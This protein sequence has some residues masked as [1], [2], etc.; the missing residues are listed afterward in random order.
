M[1]G[2][3]SPS[4]S[5][6]NMQEIGP[7]VSPSSAGA[8][9]WSASRARSLNVG[10]C[11]LGGDSGLRVHVERERRGYCP[12]LSRRVPHAGR[13]VRAVVNARGKYEQV[14][15]VGGGSRRSWVS[16]AARCTAVHMAIP[17]GRVAVFT[18]ALR[19]GR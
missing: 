19:G 5:S 13:P 18:P 12:A 17:P 15:L 16:E 7:A 8:S 10:T 9:W 11:N 2:G 6:N 14:V 1:V 4:L 3:L